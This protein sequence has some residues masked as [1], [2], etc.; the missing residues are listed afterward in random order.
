MHILK[1][2][3]KL[4]ITIEKAWSFFSDPRNL[5]EISPDY[6]GFEITSDF[7]QES[8]Y[9]GMI[10]T[11][12][13][14]P[15]LGIKMNWMTEITQ[16][17][18]Q[19]FF[20]DEQRVGPYKMWHHQHHFKVIDGGVEMIDIVNY[21]LPFGFVGKLFE[22]VLVKGKLEEIFNYREEKMK[23]LFGEMNS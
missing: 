17:K 19:L 11:Y 8:M 6:M 14:R 1:R 3:I 2:T 22:P 13:V 23:T 7:F 15:M 16:I 4:P 9:A 20:I 5:K 10:I 18:E 12:K 21:V